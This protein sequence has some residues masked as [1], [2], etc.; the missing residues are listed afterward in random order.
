MKTVAIY[1]GHTER[2]T[3]DYY[4]HPLGKG[5][6]TMIG[7]GLLLTNAHVLRGDEITITTYTGESYT[8]TLL[9][10]DK[11]KDLALISFDSLA[12]GFQMSDVNLYKGKP[13]MTIGQPLGLPQWSFSEG[14]V[15][16]PS[17]LY[18]DT[19]GGVQWGIYTDASV[20]GGASGGPLIDERG[21]LVGII[22]AGGN[23]DSYAIPMEYIKAF[24]EE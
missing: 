15:Q 19:G 4:Y 22:R 8:G 3:W 7:D 1:T 16:T 10:V 2:Y 24:L 18:T 12:E 5:T 23:E 21:E 11:L 9:R 13:I 6:G 14:T 20:K 17:L